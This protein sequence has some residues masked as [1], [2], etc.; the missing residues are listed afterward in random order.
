MRYVVTAGSVSAETQINERGSRATVD[1]PRGSVLP[2]DV[3]DEQ[4]KGF[5]ARGAVEALDELGEPD[6][7]DELDG[8]DK[9]HLVELAERLGVEIDKRWGD[10]KIAAAIRESQ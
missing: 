6:E 1:H 7:V 5:L 2:D 8:L 10:K 4:L 3:P 9:D